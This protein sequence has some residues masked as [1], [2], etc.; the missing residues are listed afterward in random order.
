ME[1]PVEQTGSLQ[2][3]AAK[4]PTLGG[5]C[6]NVEIDIPLNNVKPKVGQIELR[7]MMSNGH[8]I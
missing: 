3:P 1:S 5:I 6:S 2:P 7:D 4:E 8:H